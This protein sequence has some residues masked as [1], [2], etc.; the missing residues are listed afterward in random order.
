MQQ[1]GP[2]TAGNYYY[3]YNRGIDSC[4]LFIELNNYKYYLT[5]ILF[6]FLETLVV[7]YSLL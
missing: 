6:D 7:R 4:N 1:I 3:I 2:L 5:K